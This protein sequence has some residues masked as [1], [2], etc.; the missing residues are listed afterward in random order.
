[1]S[2][3]QLFMIKLY[4]DSILCT[5]SFTSNWVDFKEWLYLWHAHDVNYVA[6]EHYISGDD[7]YN[8]LHPID[9]NEEDWKS[10]IQKAKLYFTANSILM[11]TSSKPSFWHAMGPRPSKWSRTQDP[12]TVSVDQLEKLVGDHYNPKPTATVQRCLFNSRIRHQGKSVAEFVAACKKLL[13]YCGFTDAHLKRCYETA[14]SADQ[15][16]TMTEKGAQGQT[17]KKY[18]I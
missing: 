5:L 4:I 7:V 6:W 13:E 12:N 10:Y 15:Q 9:S 11:Q 16:W 8:M 3:H 2:F 18:W 17:T 14:W 1:M